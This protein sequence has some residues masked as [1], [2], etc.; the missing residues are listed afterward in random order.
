MGEDH[1][2]TLGALGF[3]HRGKPREAA[4]APAVR[5]HL[6]AHLIDV[7]DQDEGDARGLGRSCGDK[8]DRERGDCEQ[9]A[10]EGHE[11]V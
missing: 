8:E 7:I 11:D 5:G 6:L 2:A 3:H 4:A 1:V 10:G 9:T